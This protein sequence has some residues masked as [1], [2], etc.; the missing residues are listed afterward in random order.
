MGWRGQIFLKNVLTICFAISGDSKHFLLLKKQTQISFL[1]PNLILL[2][3]QSPSWRKVT[4]EK[5]RE[6]KKHH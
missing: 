6:S 1:T 4:R 5:E 2:L 3:L